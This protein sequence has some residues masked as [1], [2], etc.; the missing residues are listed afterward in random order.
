MKVICTYFCVDNA[1]Y[2]SKIN[3]N[4]EYFTIYLNS[5]NQMFCFLALKCHKTLEFTNWHKLFG[6]LVE[7]YE[8]EMLYIYIYIA[9]FNKYM[10]YK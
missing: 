3:N 1:I 2:E 8:L 9:S 4:N 5:L 7:I 10:I 6:N